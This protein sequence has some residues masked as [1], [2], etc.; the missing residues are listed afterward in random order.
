[1]DGRTLHSPDHFA[2]K[3]P[4][5]PGEV[6]FETRRS[7]GFEGMAQSPDGSLLYPLLEA[8]IWDAEAG[9][10]ES[11]DGRPV[12]RLFE[13]NVA[14]RD[15]TGRSWLY[16]MEGEDHAIG[17]FNMISETR[18]LIIERDGGEGDAALACPE[19]QPDGQDCFFNPAQF[20][21]VYLID[22][23][24]VAP[25][26]AVKKLAYVDLLDIDDPDGLARLGGGDGKFTFPLVTI[27]DVDMVDAEHIIVGNDNNL[28]FSTG[29][30]IGEADAN[31]WILLHVPDLL[32]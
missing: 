7:R 23:D 14:D 15:W 30:A 10:P 3:P 20:K 11:R 24:G 29:R 31:E 26:E 18:G 5:W 28:P 17:D 27:E 4:A 25:G 16:E 12:L 6:S 8:P 1:L 22:F 9:A 21:R 32:N 13:F 19:D 2:I